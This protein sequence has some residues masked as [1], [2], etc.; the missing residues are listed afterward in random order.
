MNY[1]MVFLFITFITTSLYIHHVRSNA[2]S[3]MFTQMESVLE[4]E[5]GGTNI[6]L[7]LT[8]NIPPTEA[9]IWAKF[10]QFVRVYGKI[11]QSE[12]EVIHRYQ[13][14]KQN[15][16]EA[17]ILQK[18]DDGTAEFGETKFSDLTHEEFKKE[19]TQQVHQKICHSQNTSR[20]LK[21]HHIMTGEIKE[22]L[23]KLKTRI[24]LDVPVST[25]CCYAFCLIAIVE[26]MVAIKH[27]TSVPV[28]SEQQVVDCTK[29]DCKYGG[30]P[31]VSA[32]QLI[33]SSGIMA[34]DVYPYTGKKKECRSKQKPI[35]AKITARN[36]V[37][38]DED[39]MAKALVAHGPLSIA[40]CGSPIQ[41][42][43]RGVFKP[44]DQEHCAINHG[45]D[46][47]G[48][49]TTT[50][51]GI[52][53][54]PYWVIRNSWGVGFGEEGYMR[55]YRGKNYLKVTHKPFYVEVE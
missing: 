43:K 53:N 38:R 51:R 7:K 36:L 33:N 49:G 50:I 29:G 4:S 20:I 21:F 35:L 19:F 48:F 11:Y 2:V 42:Y 47:V 26:S 18:N 45:V 28:L 32:G 17:E 10:Q 52:D 37:P 34:A 30:D 6:F 24:F 27:N 8:A 3:A 54:E 31:W 40:M 15:L 46:I 12:E 25:G 9:D 22:K 14:Y 39:Q 13:V 1:F 16:A 41:N 55:L 23:E 44:K 5:N